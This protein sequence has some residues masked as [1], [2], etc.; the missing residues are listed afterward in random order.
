[1]GSNN[2]LYIVI[3]TSRKHMLTKSCFSS[4]PVKS[5]CVMDLNIWVVNVVETHKYWLYRLVGAYMNRIVLNQNLWRT[6]KKEL[7]GEAITKGSNLFWHTQI[8]GCDPKSPQKS[9][10]N[11]YLSDIIHFLIHPCS[12]GLF[13]KYWFKY[14]CTYFLSSCP[15]PQDSYPNIFYLCVMLLLSA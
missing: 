1:M 14:L 13:L 9:N 5:A 7:G 8:P 10:T 2:N 3:R 11:R 15:I 4:F 12:L 6:F